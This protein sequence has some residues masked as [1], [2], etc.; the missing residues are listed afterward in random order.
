M[1]N[2]TSKIQMNHVRVNQHKLQIHKDKHP[3]T[4]F[5]GFCAALKTSI[6][7]DTQGHRERER[8]R[9]RERDSEREIERGGNSLFI[10]H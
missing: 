4:R 9:E 10:S 3:R 1:K 6:V 5:T 2:Q 7:T 8:L